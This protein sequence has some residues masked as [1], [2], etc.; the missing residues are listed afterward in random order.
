VI[1]QSYNNYEIIIVDDASI[2][3]TIKLVSEFF[4]KENFKS[5][6][7]II[8]KE[9]SG[10]GD[11]RNIGIEN[12]KGEYISFLDSDDYFSEYKLQR[13]NEFI[14][15]NNKPNLIADC[16]DF[17][18]RYLSNVIKIKYTLNILKTLISTTSV[19]TIKKKD[20]Y[21]FPS[22]RYCEDAFLWDKI[23]L[24]DRK[25]F[26]INEVLTFS[27]KGSRD[28]SSGLSSNLYAMH[29][30]LLGN[31]KF[32][33]ENR[34]INFLTYIFTYFVFSLKFII[35]LIRFRLLK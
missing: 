9:N 25:C 17:K 26:F 22:Q 18:V 27:I 7:I 32:L 3:S 15:D 10:P 29:V 19:C 23:I 14:N 11:S 16:C 28:F 1:N 12:A 2:D 33:Y 21:L 5:F 30:S 20:G 6:S 4:E 8:K 31:L 34:S 24:N 35:R 13:L